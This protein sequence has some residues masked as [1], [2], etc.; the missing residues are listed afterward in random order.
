MKTILTL[1]ILIITT[2]GYAQTPPPRN[3]SSL[4]AKMN[5]Q[6][7]YAQN[8]KAKEET[9]TKKV[10]LV[11]FKIYRTAKGDKLIVPEIETEYIKDREVLRKL[12]SLEKLSNL[13]EE[14]NFSLVRMLSDMG[15]K[16][17]SH[18]FAFKKDTE[19]H[20]YIFEL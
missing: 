9:K 11:E 12:K 15:Y 8:I 19:V 18:T 14:E 4:D 5:R 3:V 17:V 7:A 6:K 13:S 20:Y 1:V 16:F 2:F 10:F